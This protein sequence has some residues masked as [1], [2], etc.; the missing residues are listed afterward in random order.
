MSS[1]DILRRFDQLKVWK[2]GKNGERAPHKP[3]LVLYALGRWQRGLTVVSFREVET[4][5]K[6]LLRE[7][8][9]PRKSDH[10]EEPFWRLQNDGVW[11][12]QAPGGLIMKAGHSIPRITE[13]RSHDVKAGFSVDVQAALAND[14]FLLSEIASRILEQHFPVDFHQKILESVGLKIDAGFRSR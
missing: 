14:E 13:L 8:G 11:T 4:D 9:P 10:P 12:V 2:R 6:D 3:L 1:E 7:F 5:L